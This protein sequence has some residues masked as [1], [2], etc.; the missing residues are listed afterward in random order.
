MNAAQRT[1]GFDELRS[2]NP[3]EATR[4]QHRDDPYWG[5]LWDYAASAHWTSLRTKR[6]MI[7]SG[8]GRLRATES[9]WTPQQAMAKLATHRPVS[10]RV[11]LSALAAI[12][13]WRTITPDQLAAFVGSAALGAERSTDRDLL[14]ASELVQAGHLPSG[15]YGGGSYTLLRPDYL[16]DFDTL[17]AMTDYTDWVGITA[18][19][20]W[21]WGS[22]FDRHNLLGTELALR[23]AEF[24]DVATVLG[25]SL[26]ELADLMPAECNITTANRAAD[27]VIVRPDGMK[28]AVEITSSNSK[29]LPGKI[30]K[31]GDMLA[32]DTTKSLAVVFVEAAHPDRR[33]MKSSKEMLDTMRRSIAASGRASIDHQFADVA[34]RMMLARWTDWFPEPGQVINEFSLLPAYRA[35]GASIDDRWQPVDMLG[36]FDLD[37]PADTV[38]AQAVVDNAHLLYGTPHWLRDPSRAMDLDAMVRER[39]NV[40]TTPV[41]PPARP[42]R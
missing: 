3:V 22:Q 31:W 42:N 23:V 2:A 25:E 30:A 20:E 21:T 19:H 5:N 35:T 7:A 14:L 10:R 27:A 34:E 33:V 41:P 8:R 37:G 13:M 15:V 18:G 6:R 1:V 24:C 28:I 12:G 40:T 36:A 39:H 9:K 26:G 17:A 16:G 32:A 29:N 4:T 38:R 11:R